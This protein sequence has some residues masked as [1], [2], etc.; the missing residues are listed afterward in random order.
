MWMDQ[1]IYNMSA[2]FYGLLAAGTVF[3]NVIVILT[4][5][6]VRALLIPASFPILSLAMADVFLAS[7]VMP[8]GIVSCASGHWIFG[9]VGC[10]WY[11]FMHTTVGLSSI[12]HHAVLALERCLTIFEP[13]KKHFDRHTMT[14]TLAFLWTLVSLWSLC[15]ILGWSAYVP[16]GTGN[17]LFHRM[18]LKELFRCYLCCVYVRAF[19][20]SFPFVFIAVCYT[21]I[22]FHLRKV[23]KTAKRTWGK[24]SQITKDGV[25]VKRKAVTHG[26]IMVT[27]V[28]IT[29]LP[30][31]MVAFYTLLGF[32]KVKL[33]ALVYTITSIF[34]KTSTL[35]NPI[36]CFFWYRRFRE[37]TK[38]LCNRVMDFFL[39]KHRRASNTSQ[40]SK[41]I[42]YNGKT[43][44][45][46]RSVVDSCTTRTQNDRGRSS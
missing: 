11:A 14:R 34:A 38:K 19:S 30:Y 33:S 35:V 37:G 16:E 31:A 43:I 25:I 3:L 29:W 8:L 5:F 26:A 39:R 18:A 41:I 1:H 46:R 4:F 2:V 20:V 10:K 40:S 23:S 44:A 36:I 9:A 21:A 32:E 6:K 12:L 24:N 15:P 22:A 27:T 45:F 17:H 7:A 13:M 28:M 42:W